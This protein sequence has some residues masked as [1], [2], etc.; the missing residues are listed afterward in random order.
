MPG[1]RLNDF[2]LLGTYSNGVC[3][4][5]LCV[6]QAVGVGGAALPREFPELTSR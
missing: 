6:G 5:E 1:A 4:A 3:V 2:T